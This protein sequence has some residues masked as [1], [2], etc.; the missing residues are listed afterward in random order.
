MSTLIEKTGEMA[1]NRIKQFTDSIE[2]EKEHCLALIQLV[3]GGSTEQDT[4]IAWLSDFARQ[5]EN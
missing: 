1:I 4:A 3:E 2:C 5:S